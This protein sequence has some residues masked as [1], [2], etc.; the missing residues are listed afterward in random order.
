M[1]S[2]SDFTWNGC[3]VDWIGAMCVFLSEQLIDLSLSRVERKKKK[4]KKKRQW[5]RSVTCVALR[6]VCVRELLYYAI[7]SHDSDPCRAVLLSLL[8]HY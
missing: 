4:K 5:V 8:R 6:F 1:R 7:S 2:G 3:E